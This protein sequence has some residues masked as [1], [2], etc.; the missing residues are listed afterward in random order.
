MYKYSVYIYICVCPVLHHLLGGFGYIMLYDTVS[1]IILINNQQ[2]IAIWG[3][4]NKFM[5]R[6]VLIFWKLFSSA[7]FDA[8][9]G[10][11]PYG[12]DILIFPPKTSLVV[13]LPEQIPKDSY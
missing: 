7:N 5:G 1:H 12:T 10:G 4:V 3:A 9:L 13:S 6:K 8:H 11:I 2:S